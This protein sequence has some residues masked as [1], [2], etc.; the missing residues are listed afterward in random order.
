MTRRE[1]RRTYKSQ[2]DLFEDKI[3]KINKKTTNKLYITWVHFQTMPS[4]EIPN[5]HASDRAPHRTV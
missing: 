1:W 4:T 5:Y 2:K 3:K